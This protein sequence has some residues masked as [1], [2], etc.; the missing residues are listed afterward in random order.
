M[1]ALSDSP[2]IAETGYGREAAFPPPAD[3][4]PEP[5]ELAPPSCPAAVPNPLELLS[6]PDDPA[7]PSSG[8]LTGGFD[9][10][11]PTGVELGGPDGWSVPESV[12]APPP[13]GGTGHLLAMMEKTEFAFGW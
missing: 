3:A 6:L 7:L 8:V 12:L 2:L 13:G 5:V 11:G 4:A 9:E 1:T 10:G